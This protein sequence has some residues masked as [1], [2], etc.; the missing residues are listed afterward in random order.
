MSNYTYTELKDWLD[1]MEKNKV[2]DSALPLA[3]WLDPSYPSIHEDYVHM[4]AGFSVTDQDR[5]LLEDLMKGENH[6]LDSQVRHSSQQVHSLP[7]CPRPKQAYWDDRHFDKPEI[8]R[9]AR[10]LEKRRSTLRSEMLDKGT[11]VTQR[12]ESSRPKDRSCCE[13]SSRP[14][15]RDERF[16]L[17]KANITSCGMPIFDTTNQASCFLAPSKLSPS[18]SLGTTEEPLPCLDE[19]Y[20]LVP[21]TKDDE[22][23]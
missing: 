19:S 22:T 12:L 21:W 1:S 10:K 2:T 5:S 6:C 18:T 13:A 4:L 11:P 16:V 3:T 15:A 17:S 7:A 9:R 8:A 14:S 20:I 23:D